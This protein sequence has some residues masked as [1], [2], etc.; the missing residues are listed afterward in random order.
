MLLPCILV[1]AASDHILH[2]VFLHVTL[3]VALELLPVI[4][5][6]KRT[7]Q[8]GDELGIQGLVLINTLEF[9][10]EV[11]EQDDVIHHGYT[12]GQLQLIK[13]VPELGMSI[14]SIDRVHGDKSV[15]DPLG[16]MAAL[17]DM[18][19]LVPINPLDDLAPSYFRFGL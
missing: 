6:G 19:D 1:Q 14:Q 5:D 4:G 2:V 7:K 15:P 8:G 12:W 3:E 18:A 17:L 10:S 13:L 16:I 9:L 11:L